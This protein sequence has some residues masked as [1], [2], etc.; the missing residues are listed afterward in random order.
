M[1]L[2]SQHR[3]ARDNSDTFGKP[4]KLSPEFTNW[5]TE[6]NVE[7]NGT[8][9]DVSVRAISDVEVVGWFPNN[10]RQVWVEV[11]VGDSKAVRR[12]VIPEQRWV[13]PHA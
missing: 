9:E 6:M 3:V 11:T 1:P 5:R 7:M 8:S 12:V 2:N 10:E 4:Q 13:M